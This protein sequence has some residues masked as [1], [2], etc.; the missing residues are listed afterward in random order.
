MP[1]A[2]WRYTKKGNRAHLVQNLGWGMRRV[3]ECGTWVRLGD[4]DWYGTGS[5]AEYERV[6]ALPKCKKCLRITQQTSKE[7]TA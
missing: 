1:D 2:E 6:K 7:T 4:Y 3:S 5:H